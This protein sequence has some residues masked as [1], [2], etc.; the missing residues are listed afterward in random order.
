MKWLL[1]HY[2]LHGRGTFWIS[3]QF[4]LTDNVLKPIYSQPVL[5][6]NKLIPSRVIPHKSL[7]YCRL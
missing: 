2:T 4:N 1:S 6:S 3:F 7:K 5:N